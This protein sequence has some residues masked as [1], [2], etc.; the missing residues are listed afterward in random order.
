MKIKLVGI[1]F[2]SAVFFLVILF[3]CGFFLSGEPQPIALADE[4]YEYKWKCGNVNGNMSEATSAIMLIGG[5]ESGT[6]GE[7]AAT[8]WFLKRADRGDYLVLRYGEVGNQAQWICDNYDGLVGSAAELAINTREGAKDRDVEEYIREAEALFIA[9][10]D[11]NAYQDTWE[12]TNVEDAINY[13]INRKKVPV[14]GT[15]AGMAILGEY[16][17]APAHRDGL[18]SSEILEDPFDRNTE[19][20]DRA[21]FIDVQILRNTIT[22]SHLDRLKRPNYPETR[23][24]RLFGFLARVVDDNGIPSYGIGLE[25]GAFLAIDEQGRGK[26]F[27]NGEDRGAD[28]YFLQALE[29]P[30]RIELDEPL[31]WDR[32]G[33]AV[34]VY[35]I[36]GTRS[37][38]GSFDLNNWESASGG[39]WEYWFTIDGQ[40]GFTRD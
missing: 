21:D 13:L 30:E 20:I 35:R 19:D 37:G 8:R 24:G 3:L 22:D 15:S 1:K 18:L 11:Q 26:V 32:N 39:S 16:Y 7:D 36:R 33:K 29:K 27:G 6:E 17:Y 38:S 40:P 14:A 25:E 5:A 34:K 4:G 31:I 23:Y 2:V 12:G 10:G 28:A 9:G